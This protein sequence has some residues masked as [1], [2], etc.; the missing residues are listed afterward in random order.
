MRDLSLLATVTP[1]LLLGS[2]P[3]AIGMLRLSLEGVPEY[4]R[5]VLLREFFER[6]GVRYDAKPVGDDPIEI[7]LTLQGLPGIQL[8]SGRL[9]GACY[10]RTR[11]STDPTEDLGLV[12]NPRGLH[13]ISQRGRDVVLRDGEATLV[14][15]TEPLDTT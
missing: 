3:S 13:L 7:D 9:Q 4:E 1:E 10:R 6:L 14:S 12:V 5:P 11:E 8:L 2:R 15:L